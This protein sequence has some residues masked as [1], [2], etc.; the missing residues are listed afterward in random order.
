MNTILMLDIASAVLGIKSCDHRK[1]DA[2]DFGAA[3]K[4]CHFQSSFSLS[5]Y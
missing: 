2:N 3:F 1:G 4:V 5:C